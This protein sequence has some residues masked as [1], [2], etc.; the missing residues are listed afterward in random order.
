MTKDFLHVRDLKDD[1]DNQA[2]DLV[3]ETMEELLNKEKYND[4]CKCKICLLDIA[5][6]ALNNLPAK[7]IAHPKEDLQTKIIEFENQVNLDVVTSVDKA[8]QVVSKNP[9]HD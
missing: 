5:S 3:L 7:Y 9:R 1:L 6:Y 8:I 4:I 2:E